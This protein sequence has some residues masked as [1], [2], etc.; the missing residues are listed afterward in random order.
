MCTSYVKFV[1]PKLSSISDCMKSKLLLSSLILTAHRI[2]QHIYCKLTSL[3]SSTI[4]EIHNMIMTA[5]SISP[6]DPLP[7]IVF[8]NM[9]HSMN[10]IHSN[11]QSYLIYKSRDDGI[12]DKSLKYIIIKLILKKTSLDLVDKLQTNI[13]TSDYQ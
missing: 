2:P 1:S 8:K 12:M 5:N 7:L 11:T 3:S 6:I 13:P 9:V 10:F 4:T